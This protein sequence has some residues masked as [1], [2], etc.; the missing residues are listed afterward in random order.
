MKK[1]LVLAGGLPQISLI[2]QL[3]E[4][5]VYT[6]LADGNENCVAK[7]FADEFHKVQIFNI[8]EVKDLA[9]RIKADFIITVCADQVLLVMAKV[10]EILGLPCYINYEIAQNVSDKVKMKQIFVENEIPTS[11]FVTMMK[12]D[13]CKVADFKYP[14]VV[15]PVDSYSSRGVRKVNSIGELELYYKEASEISRTGGVIVE[16][17]CSGEELSVD[18]FIING[19][20]QILCVSNSDKILDEDRFVIYRGRCPANASPCVIK[21]IE[22]IAQK[23]ADAFG[24][25][26]APLLIQLINN[27]HHVSVVEFCARTGGNTKYLLIKKTCGVDVISAAIDLS[28]G[29]IPDIKAHST[30]NKYV[31]NDFIYCKPG[32]FNKLVGFDRLVEE[33]VIAEYHAIR[34]Q[35]HHVVGVRSSS[36]R[37]ATYNVEAKTKEELNAKLRRIITE[38]KIEDIDGKDIMR[39]D[40]ITLLD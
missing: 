4:R 40:L 5:N 29:I 30:E 17:F 20:A 39:H 11:R 27:G 19:K 22:V 31:I 32:I 13:S 16:E 14:L 23:I 3:K 26:N 15:K 37:I 1:A 6:V 2:N 18:A 21:E 36:D 12:F 9:V 28:M 33:G 24:L 34:A 35:G 7:T 8:E 10:S 38:V 25:K